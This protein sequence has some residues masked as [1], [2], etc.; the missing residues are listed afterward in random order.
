[1]SNGNPRSQ[2]IKKARFGF[3]KS[4]L[5]FKFTVRFTL[6]TVRSGR[7]VLTE[8]DSMTC[9][10]D[11]FLGMD[12]ACTTSV[13]VSISLNVFTA[14]RRGKTIENIFLGSLF[15]FTLQFFDYRG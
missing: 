15:Y 10:C 4:C 13:F 8:T 14:R 12:S 2:K 5:G 9:D 6:A 11:V 7:F 1:M 3:K